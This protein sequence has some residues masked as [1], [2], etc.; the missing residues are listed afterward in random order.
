M[1]PESVLMRGV[2][3]SLTVPL[4]HSHSIQRHTC[5]KITFHLPAGLDLIALWQ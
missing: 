2:K 4:A 5:N 1:N 3:Q